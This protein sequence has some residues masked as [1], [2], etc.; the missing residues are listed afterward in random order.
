MTKKDSLIL[1]RDRFGVKPL[2]IAKKDNNLFFSSEIKGITCLP[3]IK[4]IFN[5]SKLS[6]FFT[7][8]T[9]PGKSTFS[10]N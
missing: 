5:Q 7:F 4:K 8:L 1:A 2:I 10:R 6:D 3:Y 9:L